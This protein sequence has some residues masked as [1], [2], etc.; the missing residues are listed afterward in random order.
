MQ[1]VIKLTSSDLQTV[2]GE[3]TGRGAGG[4]DGMGDGMF[5][6]LVD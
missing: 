5:D 6:G 1:H 2:G 4:F 3:A